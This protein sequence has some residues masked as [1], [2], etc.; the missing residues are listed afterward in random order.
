MGVQRPGGDV[1]RIELPDPSSRYLEPAIETM[2]RA[3]LEALQ[4]ERI[5][6]LVPYVYQ[7]SALIRQVWEASGVHPRDITSLAAYRERAPLIDKDDVRR[8]RHEHGDRFGG[9]LCAGPA[10]L[11]V[12][13]ATSGTTGDPTPIPQQPFGPLVRGVSRDLWEAGARPRDT[14]LFSMFTIRSAHAIERFEQIGVA[15]IFLDHSPDDVGLLLEAAR[16]FRPTVHYVLNNITISAI[17]AHAEREGIDPAEAYAS[18]RTVM[19]GGEPMSDRSAA[20]LADWGV[21]AHEMSTLGDVSGTI[22]CAEGAGYHA[23][24]DLVLVEHLD[25]EGSG[26]APDG[27]PG[28]LVV[29]SLTEWAA[30]LVRYRSGDIVELTRE[31]CACGRTHARFKVRGRRSDEVV[32]AGRSILPIH[33]WPL[34]ESVPATADGLFQIV[35]AGRECD[36]LRLRVG[37][38]DPS[39]PGIAGD[40]ADAVAAGLGVPVEVEVVDADVLL[41]LGPPHKVPRVT[42]P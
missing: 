34:V 29:T 24:E 7:R 12:L 14:V 41:R 18:V 31:R 11:K 9:L 17:A 4:E 28:E 20:R 32:V 1:V 37:A 6:R 10:G 23:W 27:G 38:T 42:T 13:G 19:F 3:D 30:P 5:L 21:R 33:V 25:L 40:V 35:R 8:Y 2:P 39:A 26:P 22:S 16:R 15:P 36:V